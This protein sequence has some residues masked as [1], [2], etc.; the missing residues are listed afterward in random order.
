MENA[1][2]KGFF[3]LP[4]FLEEKSSISDGIVAVWSLTLKQLS[5]NSH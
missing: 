1:T 4:P 3:V 5:S 2:Q